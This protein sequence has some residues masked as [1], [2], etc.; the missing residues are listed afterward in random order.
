MVSSIRSLPN[1]I[2]VALRRL[3]S[4]LPYP[5]FILDNVLD[6]NEY[7]T[8]LNRFPDHLVGDPGNDGFTN[9][10]IR[11]NAEIPENISEEWKT[12]VQVLR[13]DVVKSGLVK[14]CFLS[15]YKR[16][17]SLW[18]WLLRQR[19]QNVNNY[20]INIAFS[21]NYAGRYLPPH[22]DNSYKVLALVLYF[23]PPWILKLRRGNSILHTTLKSSDEASNPSIQPIG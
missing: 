2:D 4:R 17:P 5:R 8:L 10:T 22:T 18:R 11:P 20:E 19:L 3:D 12:F 14:A 6:E 16:Y 23:A 7:S 13:S 9:Y 21:A 1:K 15:A